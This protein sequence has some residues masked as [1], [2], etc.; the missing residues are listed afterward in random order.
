[1]VLSKP[2]FWLEA[3]KSI[4]VPAIIL[5]AVMYKGGQVIDQM[6]SAHTMF[7]DRCIQQMDDQSFALKAV[8]SELGSNGKKIDLIQASN[9]EIVGFHREM[10]ELQRDTCNTLRRIEADKAEN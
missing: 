1:M 10:L 6:T 3:A 9:D 4:G 2:A 5:A 7:L 8:A